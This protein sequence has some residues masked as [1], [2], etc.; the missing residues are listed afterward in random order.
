M[1]ERLATNGFDCESFEQ[2]RDTAFNFVKKLY[3]MGMISFSKYDGT[4]ITIKNYS[5]YRNGEDKYAFFD[6]VPGYVVK[7]NRHTEDVV[8]V[9]REAYLYEKAVKAGVQNHFAR[10]YYVGTID[11]IMITIQE[12]VDVDSDFNDD[13]SFTRISKNIED[14]GAL[15]DDYEWYCKDR[16]DRGIT[17]MRYSDYR[18]DI[19]KERQEEV[20][21][22]V[23]AF[24]E[25]NPGIVCEFID[26][27]GISDVHY[28]NFGFRDKDD[29]S[30]FVIVDFS[31]SSSNYYEWMVDEWF[32]SS[33]EYYEDLKEAFREGE[34]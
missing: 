19:V 21:E 32:D 29:L 12:F 6:I 27:N 3:E 18:D 28:A 5:N 17:P 16:E 7:I 11:N 22:I 14:E 20:E 10:T 15:M 30:T 4:Y 24:V 31:G 25:D 34:E 1:F 33:V 13:V 23:Y 26:D 8:P 2:K 9:M